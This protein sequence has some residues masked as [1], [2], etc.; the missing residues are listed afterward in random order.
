MTN[1]Y[2]ETTSYGA[3][4]E[5]DQAT[6]DL[7]LSK[8]I[9]AGATGTGAGAITQWIV[10]AVNT[11]EAGT[12][13][14][15]YRVDEAR[16]EKEFKDAPLTPYEYGLLLSA[17][18]S[19]DLELQMHNIKRARENMKVRADS[20][21]AKAVELGG[22]LG[23]S[24]I[25]GVGI[26]GAMNRLGRLGVGSRV[27]V[28]GG[29]NAA[30]NVAQDTLIAGQNLRKLD[31]DDVL[32]SAGL[33]FVLGGAFD[34]LTG[35]DLSKAR[36]TLKD[37]G[38]DAGR[39]TVDDVA[40]TT[41]TPVPTPIVKNLDEIGDVANNVRIQL[42]DVAPGSQLDLFGRTDTAPQKV[43]TVDAV[44]DNTP[45][46]TKV[47][48][49][50]VSPQMELMPKVDNVNKDIDMEQRIQ[51]V[52][53][54][55][56]IFNDVKD[57]LMV[58]DL[59]GAGSRF[60]RTVAEVKD[61]LQHIQKYIAESDMPR[62]LVEGQL[63][64]AIEFIN[65]MPAGT[66][67]KNFMDDGFDTAVT[68]IDMARKGEGT[69]VVAPK[70]EVSI[71][72][73]I[74]SSAPPVKPDTPSPTAGAR[75]T[76]DFGN[77]V[78]VPDAPGWLPDTPRSYVATPIGKSAVEVEEMVAKNAEELAE[79]LKQPLAPSAKHQDSINQALETV[80]K[81]GDALNFTTKDF[82]NNFRNF[83]QAA[84]K[85][86]SRVWRH[87]DAVANAVGKTV[88]HM[89]PEEL[90]ALYKQI[91]YQEETS[92]LSAKARRMVSPDTGGKIA[93]GGSLLLGSGAVMA[94]PGEDATSLAGLGTVAVIVG[95]LVGKKFYK[96]PDMA[97]LKEA[98]SMAKSGADM[99]AIAEKTG[100]Y[101]N[102][103]SQEWMQKLDEMPNTKGMTDGELDELTDEL[104]AVTP[105]GE[106]RET[107][108]ATEGLPV[109]LAELPEVGVVKNRKVS[110]VTIAGRTF[111]LP[112]LDKLGGA[113]LSVFDSYGNNLMKSDNN[114][115]RFLATVYSA[116]DTGIMGGGRNASAADV[117]F[118]K[119]LNAK[120][121]KWHAV[122]QEQFGLWV[123]DV[124]QKKIP[125][126]GEILKYDSKLKETFDFEVKKAMEGD[127]SVS[128]YAQA[129]GE[130]WRN[131][132][133]G[134]IDDAKAI[135]KA[136]VDRGVTLPK[137]S[138]INRLASI[139]HD[140]YY[141]PRK[142]N[143]ENVKN[144]IAIHG[145]EAIEDLVA[146]AFMKAQHDLP[147]ERGFTLG[148]RYVRILLDSEN[149][150]G[151]N[152][153]TASKE[154]WINRLKDKFEAEGKEIDYDSL[155]LLAESFGKPP[156]SS[157]SSM[158][159]ARATL[160]MDHS[161]GALKMQDLYI[162]N[163]SVLAN[164][165]FRDTSGILALGYSSLSHGMDLSSQSVHSLLVGHAKKTGADAKDIKT[166]ED[167]RSLITGQGNYS[168]TFGQAHPGLT[169]LRQLTT[170]SMGADFALATAGEIGYNFKAMTN[171]I[172]NF[173]AILEYRRLVRSGKMDDA[174]ARSLESLSIG[175]SNAPMAQHMLEHGVDAKMYHGIANVANDLT[176]LNLLQSVTN[177]TKYA[178]VRSTMQRVVDGLFGNGALDTKHLSW[179]G[180]DDTLM[181][182]LRHHFKDYVVLNEKGVMVSYD[183]AGFKRA[184]PELG[185]ELDSALYR[186]AKD[187]V[188]DTSAMTASSKMF[189][190]EIGRFMF[191][192]MRPAF[193]GAMRFRRDLANFD[194]EVLQ[195]W[196]VSFS[197]GAVGYIARTYL[198]HGTDKEEIDKRLTMEEIFKGGVRNASFSGLMPNMVDLGGYMSGFGPVFTNTASGRSSS[199]APPVFSFIERATGIPNHIFDGET[200]T[201]AQLRKDL[202][203]PLLGGHFIVN[204]LTEDAPRHV[205]QPR[206]D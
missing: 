174:M 36:K 72:K 138:L 86:G 26:T 44:F 1:W 170:S 65:G 100:F 117:N 28:A 96:N 3:E 80:L 69:L 103:V 107:V 88:M 134:I 179:T 10:D 82:K 163:A 148:K 23:E 116:L 200:A 2:Q 56:S 160:D 123:R 181:E 73:E 154:D 131:T 112:L 155:V 162:Q 30:L 151:L 53:D 171:L 7:P 153:T 114:T 189:E 126:G 169:A 150:V 166:I 136:L 63:K 195:R 139:I 27:A 204:S 104:F 38:F 90:K 147:I 58:G 92:K 165:Y 190:N 159:K 203:S 31:A 48:A 144:L 43:D 11:P 183:M 140:P 52:Y 70:A 130:H 5:K 125:L 182:G 197:M 19:V 79:K 85:M 167:I 177:G 127:T 187:S 62:E 158:L 49:P 122:T 172:R 132:T 184:F 91:R 108:R 75:I 205:R 124:K 194:A 18:N 111:H 16:I 137:D 83:R 128:T 173:P 185:N 121:T 156:A 168:D 199:I 188:S 60:G 198:R 191:Q 102:P 78:D 76:D 55:N 89:K 59:L 149:E 6:S 192:F 71:A 135:R 50:E 51:R 12:F 113:V 110:Y 9:G 193:V 57:A 40:E 20:T 61:E 81:E 33:G 24:M 41:P 13:D 206:D 186:L 106:I 25:G 29:A 94:S 176:R 145:R 64:G 99:D 47:E 15:S 146:V 196:M 21:I 37:N 201:R 68:L 14:P 180:L 34:G 152:F 98:K 17:N 66:L 35:K 133:K 39:K 54:N 105:D 142:F 157:G 77:E 8:K 93:I 95:I 84:N 32:F 202:A 87:M 178:V 45:T 161:E 4:L 119:E 67:P 74:Q 115:V 46:N 175:M 164:S 120:V 129:V 42:D 143:Y 141:V 22:T 101:K 109:N 118:S 97:K